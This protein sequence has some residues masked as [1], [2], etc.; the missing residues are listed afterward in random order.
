MM[1]S[2]SPL[3]MASS[4]ALISLVVLKRESSTIRTGQ[5]AKRSFQVAVMQLALTS[6]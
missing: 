5:S 4:A 1:M 3:A 2:A 6:P